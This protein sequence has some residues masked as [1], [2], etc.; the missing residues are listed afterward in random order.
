M[1]MEPVNI[2]YTFVTHNLEVP[3]AHKIRFAFY[4]CFSVELF[5]LT[6]NSFLKV[7]R[8]VVKSQAYQEEE[9]IRPV[10]P[11][12]DLLNAYIYYASDGVYSNIIREE[13]HHNEGNVAITSLVVR[14]SEDK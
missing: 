4:D 14:T 5:E 3:S 9:A 8:E 12:K 2:T 1:A 10:Y 11:S 7:Y 13:A 6:K